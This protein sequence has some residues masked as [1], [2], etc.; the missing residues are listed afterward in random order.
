MIYYIVI[1]LKYK[2]MKKKTKKEDWQSI[3][4]DFFKEIISDYFEK[5][6]DLFKD[7]VIEVQTDDSNSDRIFIDNITPEKTGRINFLNQ[8][9]E[10]TKDKG[11]SDLAE[12]FNLEKMEKDLVGAVIMVSKDREED[13]LISIGKILLEGCDEK[14]D[15]MDGIDKKLVDQL[16]EKIKQLTNRTTTFPLMSSYVKE[17]LWE[18]LIISVPPGST[19]IA[20]NRMNPVWFVKKDGNEICGENLQA[21]DW[22]RSLSDRYVKIRS[23][24]YS[25]Y[26][27]LI[28]SEEN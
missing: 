21:E 25:D 26:Q 8:F 11:R 28:K 3:P 22:E 14:R 12:A 23:F 27:K 1:K 9:K 16:R 17:F 18:G 7:K 19:N 15:E 13:P 2:F 20:G 5:K 24:D 6:N 4:L 10:Y